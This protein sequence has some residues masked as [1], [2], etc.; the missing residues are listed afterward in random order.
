MPS[1]SPSRSSRI[2]RAL[3]P[4]LIGS[5]VVGFGT[6]GRPAGAATAT[7][8]V[9]SFCLQV[10]NSQAA[11]AKIAPT[12]KSRLSTIATEWSKIERFAPTQV[13]TD[14]TAVKTAYA[15]ASTQTG[16]AATATLG[17]LAGPAGRITA[18][19]AKSC[20]AG[21]PGGDDGDRATRRAELAACLAKEGVTLPDFGGG[22]GAG[23]QG[24]G[25]GGPPTFDA[26]TQAAMTKCGGLGGP[27]GFGGGRGLTD[28]VRA[29]LTKKGVTIP[30]G[31]SAGRA[32]AGAGG[33]GGLGARDPKFAAA[34]QE[35]RAANPAQSTTVAAH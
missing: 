34:L 31:R 29:C 13:K 27:G 30:A 8:N 16:A 11:I 32:G 7:P 19:T 22:Q 23:G 1:S 4:F 2:R 12:A 18:F 6:A 26:K 28:E 14:V 15:K 10:T 20:V 33:A 21:G 9:Q 25:Q 3:V 5:S 17:K 35:C 24:G